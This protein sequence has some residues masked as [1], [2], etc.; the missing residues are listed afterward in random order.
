MLM[1]SGVG[2]ANVLK[3]HAIPVISNLQGVGQNMWDH[4]LFGA[5]YQVTTPTHSALSNAS[6]FQQAAE[7]YRNNGS[8]VLGNPGGDILAWEKLP[9]PQRLSLSKSTQASLATFPP[10]WP[11]LEYLILD[12][13]SGDNGNYITEAPRTP[14]M[15]VSPAAAIVAP[16]SRG[17]VSISSADSAD[18]PLINPNWLSHPADKELAVAAFKRIRELMATE[19]VQNVTVGEEIIPGPAVQ[20][21]TEILAAIKRNGI[22]TFHAS[23]TCKYS[24]FMATLSPILDGENYLLIKYGPNAR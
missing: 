2:P 5:S 8:G 4:F 15:Y 10:D 22:Q 12:A 3:Q 21:D 11:E 6:F 9:E 16:Q 18:P 20:T 7:Q 23:A 24:S 13:Y 17:N 1:L 14:Y 19:T